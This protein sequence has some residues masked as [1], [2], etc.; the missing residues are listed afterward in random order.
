MLIGPN[1]PHKSII[2]R[3][4]LPTNVVVIVDAAAGI[5]DNFLIRIKPIAILFILI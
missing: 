3:N 2:N 4:F 1:K 5:K